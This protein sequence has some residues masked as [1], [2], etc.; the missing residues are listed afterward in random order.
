MW[1]KRIQ[2]YYNDGLWTI[3]QVKM[4]VTKG[5]ITEEEYKVITGE[6]YTA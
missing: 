2:G 3:D 1:F 4:A 6:D 5:K